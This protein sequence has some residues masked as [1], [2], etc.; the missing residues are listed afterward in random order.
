MKVR[1]ISY[2]GDGQDI[3]RSRLEWHNKQ[4][5]WLL[6]RGL[7]VTIFDQGYK[8]GWYRSD[9]S[10]TYAR[11]HGP[12]LRPGPARNCLLEDFYAGDEDWTVMADNDSVLIDQMDGHSIF[13]LVPQIQENI[14]I[15]SPINGALRG[16]PW[17]AK[18]DFFSDFLVLE[19]HVEL[20]GSFWFLRKPP[21]PIWFNDL[22]ICEDGDFVYQF[23]RKGLG[24]FYCQNIAL[25]EFASGP[26]SSTLF[27][28]KQRK[29]LL[30]VAKEKLAAT[31][32]CMRFAN[33]RLNKRGFID[34]FWQGPSGHI[35]EKQM[36]G[37]APSHKKLFSE[38]H[39]LTLLKQ[40]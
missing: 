9:P 2:M 15:I 37:F 40:T 10:I 34:K 31:H 18:P 35:I 1:I 16:Y 29:A 13:S 11:Y 4:L 38:G 25:R 6:A 32:D 24:S 36:L 17:R 27:T 8:E 12:L 19:R 39:T 33:G 22:D 26:S 5:D 23:V 7:D 30:D 3:Q 14:Y 28:P 20:K 21:E